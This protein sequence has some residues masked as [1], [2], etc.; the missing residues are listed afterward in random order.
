MDKEKRVEP[1]QP[2]TVDPLKLQKPDRSITKPGTLVTPESDHHEYKSLQQLNRKQDTKIKF[3]SE[4]CRKIGEDWKKEFNAMLNS[5]YGTVHFGITDDC[6]VEEGIPLTEK[7][8]D[9]IRMRVSQSF[10]KFYPAVI[11]HSSFSIYFIKMENGLFR[12]DVYIERKSSLDTVFMSREN[13][14]AYWRSGGRCAQIPVDA[15]R[16]RSGTQISNTLKACIEAQVIL[17]IR[18]AA[19]AYHY[20]CTEDPHGKAVILL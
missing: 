3:V 13:S 6:L 11:H 2:T 15:I 5:K 1:S 8:Q 17:R 9:Q 19:C 10:E 12:F 20:R 14:I 18:D 16:D 4:I 7:D